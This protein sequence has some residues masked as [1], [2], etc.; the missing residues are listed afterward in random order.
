MLPRDTT[1]ACLGVLILMLGSVA[2]TSAIIDGAY[3]TCLERTFAADCFNDRDCL[4]S[5]TEPSYKCLYT[6]TGRRQCTVD[7]S[8]VNEE[9]PLIER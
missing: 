6:M 3:L 2:S 4:C 8:S 5:L 7:W 1:L 9:D